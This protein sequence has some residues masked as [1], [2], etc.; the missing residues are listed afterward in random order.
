M[1]TLN[2]YWLIV[3]TQA[4]LRAGFNIPTSSLPR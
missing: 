4:W 2:I 1:E 3:N